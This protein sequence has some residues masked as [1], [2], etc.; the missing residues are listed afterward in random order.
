MFAIILLMW[1]NCVMKNSVYDKKY[2]FMLEK[3]D[4]KYQLCYDNKIQNLSIKGQN[5]TRG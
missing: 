5:I 3:L 2:F 4:K 1:A